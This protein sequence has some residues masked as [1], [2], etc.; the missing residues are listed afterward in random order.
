LIEKTCLD[1]KW[2]QV[3]NSGIICSYWWETGVPL[4]PICIADQI[5]FIIRNKLFLAKSCQTFEERNK[6]KMEKTFKELINDLKMQLESKEKEG[7]IVCQT[8][9]QNEYYRLCGFVDC[10]KNIINDFDNI[11]IK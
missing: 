3:V 10:L 11:V 1:C 4:L 6:I 7:D 8:I 9:F 2:C 5:N